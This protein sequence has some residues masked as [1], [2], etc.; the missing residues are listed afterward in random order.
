MLV[1]V[2][3]SKEMFPASLFSRVSLFNAMLFLVTTAFSI[4]EIT[5]S[6]RSTKTITENVAIF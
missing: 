5:K 3:N 2:L 4:L 1:D 6:K